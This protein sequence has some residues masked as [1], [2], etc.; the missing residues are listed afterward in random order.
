MEQRDILEDLKLYL[1]ENPIWKYFRKISPFSVQCLECKNDIKTDS[2]PA[3]QILEDHLS[4]AHNHKYI[5]FKQELSKVNDNLT[6][7][8]A[9]GYIPGL[10]GVIKALFTK[11]N[12]STFQCSECEDLVIVNEKE[13]LSH[14]IRSH[15]NQLKN[16]IKPYSSNRGKIG[17]CFK[18]NLGE[19]F[20]VKC[21]RATPFAS[22]TALESHDRY[23][24]LKER[25]YPCDQ[26][27]RTFIRSDE[28]KLHMRYHQDR[29]SKKGAMCS[30]CGMVFN[31]S[32]SRIRHENTVHYNIR[33]HTC[34][35]CGKK[36]ASTQALER[37]SRI[38]SDVK[39]HQCNDCGQQFREIAHLKVHYRTHSGEKPISCPHC[40]QRFKHYAGRKSHKCEGTV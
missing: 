7:V 24:H 17:D 12:D 10:P 35:C 13:R 39:P 37:H 16:K 36:F 23:I 5:N 19:C 32:A 18:V 1:L 11:L 4:Y 31:S 9:N 27:T 28:L 38:H 25:P 14:L 6:E 30:Q 21:D 29:K 3:R 40:S 34:T 8:A 33:R 26:C 2:N 15:E 22:A 20:C